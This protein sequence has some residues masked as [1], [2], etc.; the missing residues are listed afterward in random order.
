M[1]KIFINLSAWT[2]LVLVSQTASAQN[3]DSLFR[4]TKRAYDSLAKLVYPHF[5]VDT[6]YKK[7]VPL[8]TNSLQLKLLQD[9]LIKKYKIQ[10]DSVQGKLLL[11][12]KAKDSVYG[13]IATS[14]R[15]FDSVNRKIMRPKYAADS[16]YKKKRVFTTQ[17]DSL[18]RIYITRL[19]SFHKYRL[20]ESVKLDSVKRKIFL[21]QIKSDSMRIKKYLQ[22]R[23]LLLQK[24]YKDT[25]TLKNGDRSRELLTEIS[26]FE[27]DT[28]Y[29]NNN[30]RKV[31]LKII[32]SQKIRLSSIIICKEMVNES[33]QLLFKKMG[34][35]IY[36]DKH[37]VTADINSMQRAGTGKQNDGCDEILNSATNLK[38]PLT[39]ELPAN[40]IVIINTKYATTNIENYITNLKAEITNGTLIMGNAENAVIKTAYSTVE[41]DDIQKGDITLA[42]SR[43]TGGN[44]SAVKIASS[45]SNIQLNECAEMNFVSVSDNYSIDKAGSILGTKHF[46]KLNI[47]HL[48]DRL[49]LSGSGAAVKIN[50]LNAVSPLIKIDSKFT[51]V[52]L[53]LSRQE[54]FAVYY[55]GSYKDVNNASYATNKISAAGKI[56]ATSSVQKDTLIQPLDLNKTVLKAIAGNITDKHTK[57]D[58]VCPYCNVV[59]N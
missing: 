28:V 33:D 59:F 2:L 24:M 50:S 48:K 54:N 30:Y 10:L 45:A 18:K 17:H 13:K 31:V 16:V 8:K 35:E 5:V 40:V 25:I 47:E 57:I 38:R 1:K 11:S 22:E 14:H 7:L 4:Q 26:C 3:T 15:L 34:I 52:E 37:S 19:D 56:N 29:I 27:G 58:I 42:T 53:P 23:K 49:V 20:A 39:I 21:R 32:P 51:D 46:G 55:E 12:Y 6:V 41:A 44:I 36:R 43:F 9:T